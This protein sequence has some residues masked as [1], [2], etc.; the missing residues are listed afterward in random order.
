MDKENTFILEHYPEACCDFC[1]ETVHN[2]FSCPICEIKYAGTSLY[3]SIY[4]EFLPIEFSCEEC[5][6]EFEIIEYNDE[7]F[8]Y[9]VKIIKANKWE[10]LKSF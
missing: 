2:H 9:T 8:D 7:N 5:N 4:E 1:G 6:S 10:Y 3:N